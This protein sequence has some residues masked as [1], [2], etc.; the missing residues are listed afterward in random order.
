LDEAGEEDRA[1]II[2]LIEAIHTA[3][4]DGDA[5]ALETARGQLQDLL[6][7]LGT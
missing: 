3:R 1:E 2:D 6:F 5:A 7:Y 4:S